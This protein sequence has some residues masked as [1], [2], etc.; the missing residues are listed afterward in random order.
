MINL[1]RIKFFLI[2][3]FH[4]GFLMI[5]LRSFALAQS[6]PVGMPVLEDYYRRAQLSGD[7]DSSVSF[8]I[9]PLN[10]E[11]LIR[12][13]D[14]FRLDS[15]TFFDIKSSFP[16][17]SKSG[18]G[19]IK[20]LPVTFQQQY[21]SRQPY[22][23]NDGAM[24]PARG[25][26][27]LLSF[28][29]YVK[30]K[31]LSVQI[32]PE[33]V[34]AE[35]RYFEGFPS[36][37]PAVVWARYYDYYFNLIDQPE[38]FG[39]GHYQKIWSG[40]SNVTLTFDPVAFGLSTENLWWGPGVRNSLLM[41][42][43]ARGFKHL[44][45]HTVRP[46]KTKWGSLEGEMI[47]GR[48]ENSG[49]NPPHS[50]SLFYG[51]K[52]LISKN[53]EWRYLS[54]L[55][56]TYQPKWVKGLFLGYARTLQSYHSDIKNASDYFPLLL[57]FKKFRQDN[58]HRTNDQYQSFFARWLFPEVR[59]EVYFE[60][61]L[62][63]H[64]YSMEN[65]SVG[66]GH[67]RAYT[68]GLRKL[69]PLNLKGDQLQINWEMTQLQAP[70]D[71]VS[72]PGESWYVHDYVRQGYTNDG[73]IIG[74]GIG[75]G[76]SFQSLDLAWCRGPRRIGLLIERYVHNNDFYYYT[77]QTNRDARR[78]WAD[79]SA[80]AKFEWSFKNLL[81]NASFNF[82]RSLNY[83]WTIIPDDPVIYW[84]PGHDVSNIQSQV[85]ISYCF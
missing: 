45:F 13:R 7:L 40:Q 8:T 27:G 58:Y 84:L 85:G 76:S 71:Y 9:R 79:I 2:R 12:G 21:N 41:G 31:F 53:D 6:I 32:R 81:V 44:T 16:L 43:T 67:S 23:W 30:Y 60:Y 24:I 20:L 73:E 82:I 63:N 11:S 29:G 64:P 59:G 38:R 25:Y 80:A 42:N 56:L 19:F 69:V 78:H 52:L 75:P 37:H 50:D 17:P 46:I 4:T 48:L 68:F 49:F 47:A 55:V 18:G 33:I 74:A 51:Q 34:F 5:I 36:D 62:N 3:S 54:G 70:S 15:S 28:G 35:N 83:Q 66:S 61:G 22:G 14:L 77:F 10:A 65:Y 26:Q 72:Q 39:N 57:P 1:H